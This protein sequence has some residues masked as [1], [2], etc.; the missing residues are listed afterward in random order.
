MAL[1]GDQTTFA[2]SWI[3]MNL[4]GSAPQPPPLAQVAPRKASRTITAISERDKS[5]WTATASERRNY[6]VKHSKWA[7][8]FVFVAYNCTACFAPTVQHVSCDISL[9]AT[10]VS[11]SKLIMRP[12]GNNITAPL[13]WR[14]WRGPNTTLFPQKPDSYSECVMCSPVLLCCLSSPRCMEVI[15]FFSIKSM[16]NID[17]MLLSHVSDSNISPWNRHVISNDSCCCL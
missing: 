5:R 7:E 2:G 11:P 17:L 15:A 3:S 14:R 10:P 6:K 16:A 9:L 8:S 4:S 13:S 12:D 1:R